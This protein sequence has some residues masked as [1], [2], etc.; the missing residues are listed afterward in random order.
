MQRR[1]ELMQKY[2]PRLPE[3]VQQRITRWKHPTGAL[4]V[5][6]V[7]RAGMSG[8]GEHP[9][10]SSGQC[11]NFQNL[12]NIYTR[13]SQKKDKS[14]QTRANAAKLAADNRQLYQ[15][16]LAKKASATP[17]TPTGAIP[18]PVPYVPYVPYYP[19]GGGGGGAG[20]P[21]LVPTLPVEP[22][23]SG[24]Y[25]IDQYGNQVP[26]VA[27]PEFVAEEGSVSP[28]GGTVYRVLATQQR[29]YIDATTGQRIYQNTDGTWG[30]Q[31]AVSGTPLTQVP[32]VQM[33][34]EGAVPAY[35]ESGQLVP[36]GQAAFA[37]LVP[38]GQ[39]PEAGV[40]AA[41][42]TPFQPD[43]WAQMPGTGAAAGTINERDL[44]AQQGPTEYEDQWGPIQVLELVFP[45]GQV[46]AQA[47]ITP[48]G[49][50]VMPGGTM[51]VEEFTSSYVLEGGQ[52]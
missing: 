52:W 47:T 10:M 23:T 26:C 44:I 31:T 7:H 18:V 36:Y 2:L 22:P 6:I 37:T 16:C 3:K 8:L 15:E 33:P 4:P 48:S 50:G 5:P 14:K 12:V 49:Q 39:Q 45:A 43:P 28:Q 13:L 17:S 11:Q 21:W 29:F 30:A 42:T 38:Y 35:D 27:Q 9:W 19:G 40:P 51:P 46:A 1:R 20:G 34:N 32:Y 41:P 24:G 25:C